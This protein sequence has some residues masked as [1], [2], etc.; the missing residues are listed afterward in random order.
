MQQLILEQKTTIEEVKENKLNKLDK[1]IFYLALSTRRKFEKNI[2]RQTN[3]Q[4]GFGKGR[5][6][7]WKRYCLHFLQR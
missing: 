4:R 6:K 3:L 1:E 5:K 2:N 7:L